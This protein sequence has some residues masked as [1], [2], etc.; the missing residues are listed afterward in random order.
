V[1]HWKL[2]IFSI[3]I[4]NGALLL[5]VR[6]WDKH[7]LRESDMS[8]ARG[9]QLRRPLIFF[10]QN[11]F[12]EEKVGPSKNH[13]FLRGFL[14]SWLST[15]KS[16]CRELH[17]DLTHPKGKYCCCTTPRNIKI[18]KLF[19]FSQCFN[20]FGASQNSLARN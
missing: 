18:P 9:L 15:I 16:G 8:V 10:F 1:L 3:I 7:F 19:L 13:V 5:L 4:S 17:S 12:L 14:I 11:H 20:A 2:Y 6:F